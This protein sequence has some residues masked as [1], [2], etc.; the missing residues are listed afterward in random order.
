MYSTPQNEIES[1]AVHGASLT[2]NC[3]QEGPD[4]TSTVSGTSQE[5]TQEHVYSRAAYEL[6]TNQPF[7][8]PEGNFHLP[9]IPGK[10]PWSL[11]LL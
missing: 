7:Q 8:S 11:S 9:G 1:C 4:K 5:W 6:H 3:A 2:W 10:N